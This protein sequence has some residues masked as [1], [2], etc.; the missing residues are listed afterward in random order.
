MAGALRSLA[1][2]G[3][4]LTTVHVSAGGAALAAVAEEARA[5]A[6]SG[7]P[8]PLLLGVTRLTSLAAPDPSR[9]WDD[10][11]RLGGD[12]VRAGI[13]GWIAPVA[14][15]GALRP[16]HGPGPVLVCPG[17]R[18]PEGARGDQ[19]E[20]GTPEAAVSE[21][22]DWIVVGRPIV[23]AEDPAAAVRSFIQRLGER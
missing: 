11:V 19:V 18:L 17:I 5:L 6:S 21:G 14:A 15:A 16:A 20:V 13:D 3:V 8:V 4:G 1:A 10:V 7:R 2:H 22:A 9:P 12:A 23:R